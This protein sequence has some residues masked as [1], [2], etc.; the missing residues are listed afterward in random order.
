MHHKRVAE[1][2]GGLNLPEGHFVVFGGSTLAIRDI[3]NANDI[4]LFITNNLYQKL[5]KRGWR[6]SS[7]N[8]EKQYLINVVDG[9]EIQAYRTWQKEGWQ[10]NFQEY[11]QKPEI[12]RGIPFMPLSEMYLWKVY[13]ARQKDLDDVQLIDKYRSKVAI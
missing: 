1:I 3:R 12:I 11:L 4:D 7:K 5:L 13:T 9:I 8:I 2:I 10:P 6:K